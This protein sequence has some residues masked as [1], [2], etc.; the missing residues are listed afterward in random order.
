MYA[1]LHFL[2]FY[3]FHITTASLHFD[4]RLPSCAVYDL[5]VDHPALV[6]IELIGNDICS[7]HETLET[8]TEPQEFYDNV[9]SALKVLDEF[10]PAGT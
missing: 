9:V 1:T 2:F 5:A 6:I 4:R 7:P 3:E 10:L 8:M